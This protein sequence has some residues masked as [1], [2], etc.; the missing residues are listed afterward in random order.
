MGAAPH[1]LGAAP[2]CTTIRPPR[3]MNDSGSQD[4]ARS[5]PFSA[6]DCTYWLASD[7]AGAST[8]SRTPLL[9]RTSTVG[10]K[11]FRRAARRGPA[12][13]GTGR[14]RRTRTKRTACPGRRSPVGRTDPRRT[15]CRQSRRV[16]AWVF[17]GDAEP[18]VQPRCVESRL[19]GRVVAEC[20]ATLDR[21]VAVLVVEEPVEALDGVEAAHQRRQPGHVLRHHPGVRRT[22]PLS[23]T[24]IGRRGEAGLP[25]AVSL[26]GPLITDRRIVSVLPPATAI[27]ERLYVGA[28]PG[29]PLRKG[30]VG[31][32]VLQRFGGT[33]PAVA[34]ILGRVLLR[35]VG[36]QSRSLPGALPG[37]TTVVLGVGV[38]HCC[39]AHQGV[40]GATGIE[41]AH[42]HRRERRQRR[43]GRIAGHHVRG[44]VVV[45]PAVPDALVLLG[46]LVHRLG[47]VARDI[48]LQQGQ[49][50]DVRTVLVP[51]GE[52]PV[53]RSLSRREPVDLQVAARGSGRPRR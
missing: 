31:E 35:D 30:E 28:E 21:P 39:L 53:L 16:V 48:R 13:A 46:E 49:Q 32:R 9:R 10:T 29:T 19:V 38:L 51:A 11:G 27:L 6:S 7:V 18:V 22:G 12:S 44:S 47:E 52:G 37:A 36:V 17:H 40:I 26:P 1:S 3:V 4:S 34:G 41:I 23:E 42:A 15:R 50:L 8:V 24:D 33:A 20:A 5:R 25:G 43:R 45:Q 2:I 14:S